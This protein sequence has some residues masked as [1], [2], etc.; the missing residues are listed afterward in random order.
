MIF[1]LFLFSLLSAS[2]LQMDVE[3]QPSYMYFSDLDL[4]DG[5]QDSL[6]LFT[7]RLTFKTS[8]QKEKFEIGFKLQSIGIAGSTSP[9]HLKGLK[10]EKIYPISVVKTNFEPFIEQAY[11]KLIEPFLLPVNL[12]IGKQEFQLDEGFI[13]SDNTFG[14]FGF[15]AYIFY[16]VNFTSTFFYFLPYRTI[17]GDELNTLGLHIKT[18]L[19]NHIAAVSYIVKNDKLQ[20]TY[21]NLKEE[22][23]SSFITLN[24]GRTFEKYYYNLF[25]SY[26]GGRTSSTEVSAYA[27]MVNGGIKIEEKIG[28]ASLD[29]LLFHRSGDEKNSKENE[30]FKAVLT[31]RFDGLNRKGIGNLFSVN[32][33]DTFFPMQENYSG[34]TSLGFNFYISPKILDKFNFTASS[35]IFF[36]DKKPKN[37]KNELGS[38]FDF[39]ITYS[40]LKNINLSS[41]LSI[42][43]PKEG[44]G[45]KGDTTISHL[46]L[47]MIGEF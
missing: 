40:L 25:I 14:L 17:V 31:K 28:K 32:N 2:T 30:E 5:I 47:K 3:Y 42:F 35:H 41:N 19:Q 10:W 20:I 22:V 1:T 33:Y 16:P 46:E 39:G 36:A 45:V 11:I 29:I 8:Y 27:F 9:F 7:S 34:L 23:I 6:N 37:S 24:I 44:L 18:K 26:Q 43:L 12:V 38:E 13:I 21:T 4:T 15:S